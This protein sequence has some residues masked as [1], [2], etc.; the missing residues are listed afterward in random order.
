MRNFIAILLIL[1]TLSCEGQSGGI[2]FWNPPGG[3]PPPPVDTVNSYMPIGYLLAVRHGNSDILYVAD[4]DNN[5]VIRYWGQSN[6]AAGRGRVIVGPDRTTAPYH[7]RYDDGNLFIGEL[8]P[9]P[10]LPHRYRGERIKKLN[11]SSNVMTEVYSSSGPEYNFATFAPWYTVVEDDYGYYMVVGNTE[12]TPIARGFNKLAYVGPFTSLEYVSELKDGL[13]GSDVQFV[14]SLSVEEFEGVKR[15]VVLK[16]IYTVLGLV[17]SEV[18]L[19]IGPGNYQTIIPGLISPGSDIRLLA[20][21]PSL[22]RPDGRLMAIITGVTQYAASSFSWQKHFSDG[23]VV[24]SP[25][26]QAVAY[27]SPVIGY[28]L[29]SMYFIMINPSSGSTNLMRENENGTYTIVRPF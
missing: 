26:N 4:T 10:E 29:P 21:Y 1:I 25:Y 22:Y 8:G 3:T 13:E 11:L 27:A 9:Q 18:Y 28:S 24:N 17:Q 2:G 19:H 5:R 12:Y 23:A 20:A 16:N 14:G 7:L 6:I 15:L